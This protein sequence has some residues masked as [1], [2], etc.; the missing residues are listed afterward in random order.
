MLFRVH[1]QFQ[2]GVMTGGTKPGF[3]MSELL[4]D[5][6]CHLSEIAKTSVIKLSHGFIK[7]WPA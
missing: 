7:D 4:V 3:C 6:F 1:C 2:S 5:H